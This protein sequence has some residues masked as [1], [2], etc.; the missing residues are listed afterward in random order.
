[1]H[2]E[3]PHEL[4]SF[5][6]TYT[7]LE[8]NRVVIQSTCKYCLLFKTAYR[9]DGSLERWELEHQCEPELAKAG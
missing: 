3:R 5:F 4:C 2:V 6:H 9:H 7:E 8:K 1:M